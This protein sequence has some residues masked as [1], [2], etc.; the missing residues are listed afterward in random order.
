MPQTSQ[1]KE[2]YCSSDAYSPLVDRQASEIKLAGLLIEQS[3]PLLPTRIL[4]EDERK[5]LVLEILSIRRYLHGRYMDVLS[6][7]GLGDL[8]AKVGQRVCLMEV[9]EI[10]REIQD[11]KTR[12]QVRK[13]LGNERDSLTAEILE[14]LGF[15]PKNIFSRKTTSGDDPVSSQE[16]FIDLK[17]DVEEFRLLRELFPKWFPQE[18]LAQPEAL[19]PSLTLGQATHFPPFARLARW[20]TEANTEFQACVREAFKYLNGLFKKVA[21]T[22][23]IS[24]PF[25]TVSDLGTKSFVALFEIILN[26]DVPL[27]RRFEAIRLLEWAIAFFSVQRNPIFQA[28]QKVRADIHE[29]LGIGVWDTNDQFMRLS[30]PPAVNAAVEKGSQKGGASIQIA[31]KVNKEIQ[32]LL[33]QCAAGVMDPKSCDRVIFESREKDPFSTILKI[34][35][36]QELER[37]CQ[38][39]LK[40]MKTNITKKYAR[41][42]LAEFRRRM[43]AHH[44]KIDFDTKPIGF[45]TLDDSVG[46][47][48]AINLQ[49]PLSEYLK[50]EQGGVNTLFAKLAAHLAEKL[51]LKNIRKYENHLW[52]KNRANGKTSDDFRVYKLHGDYEIEA[53][54]FENGRR[55]KRTISVPVEVQLLPVESHL[56][57][58]SPG[59]AGEE[60]Y[61]LR[62]AMDMVQRLH[63]V[64]IE[65]SPLYQAFNLDRFSAALVEEESGAVS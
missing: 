57:A 28:Q 64:E 4:H 53:E 23:P 30:I 48:I 17:P 9:E 50:E 33:N 8:R 56:R 51:N 3:S 14:R 6:R 61:S 25:D 22:G 31:R 32:D 37:K 52:D 63:P 13:A 12:E 60:E 59:E 36:Y 7:E 62:K 10:C 19:V 46:F 21:P 20:I 41:R 43:L 35:L 49:K 2:D 38:A 40:G 27:R 58:L 45:D 1:A 42:K 24:Q 34:F 55:V 15:L 47:S 39:T 29:L 54:V 18:S 11:G 44:R 65:G 16:T 26:K 5:S